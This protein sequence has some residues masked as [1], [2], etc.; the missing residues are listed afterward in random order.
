MSVDYVIPDSADDNDV[1]QLEFADNVDDDVE[2]ASA[3]ICSPELIETQYLQNYALFLLK[4]QRIH[5]LPSGTIRTIFDEISLLHDL[6]N[7]R[8]AY[9]AE[10]LLKQKN[11]EQT[12]A[13]E[14]LSQIRK[15][16]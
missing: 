3:N 16:E 6:E 5:G 14:I 4:L 9:L 15:I 11:I 12:K 13:L 10:H 7:E 8:T 2:Q 1:E